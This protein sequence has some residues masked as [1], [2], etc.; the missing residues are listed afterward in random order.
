LSD[1]DDYFREANERAD[2]APG[3]C[4]IHYPPAPAR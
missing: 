1:I 4:P 3:A 2:R